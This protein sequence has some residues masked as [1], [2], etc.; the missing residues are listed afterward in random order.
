MTCDFPGGSGPPSPHSGSAHVCV[1]CDA[2]ESC[3][4]MLVFVVCVLM[5]L[6]LGTI[7]WSVTVAILGQTHY[8]L[9][10]ILYF[11]YAFNKIIEPIGM[12]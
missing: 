3:F 10:N 6:S 1:R 11:I 4:H 9:T 5:P 12:V 2:T 7:G 8:V